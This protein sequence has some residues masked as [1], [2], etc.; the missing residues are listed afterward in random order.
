MSLATARFGE[1]TDELHDA[2]ICGNYT[3]LLILE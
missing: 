3:P 1:L 2:L